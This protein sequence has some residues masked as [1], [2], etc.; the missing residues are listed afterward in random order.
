MRLFRLRAIVTLAAALAAPAHAAQL[1][2]AR[3]IT[4]VVPD[5]PGGMS[6]L[7]A[8]VLAP[9]LARV[10]NQ[11]VSVENDPAQD[12]L[13]AAWRVSRSPWD[14]YTLLLAP[15]ATL[16]DPKKH[17]FASVAVVSTAPL[18]LVA[19]AKSR[20]RGV[21][22]L[23]KLA[24][25]K[26]GSLSYGAV[27][28]RRATG[29]A[30]EYFKSVAGVDLRRVQF[31]TAAEAL[32]AL[33][34]GKVDVAFVPL[35]E[36]LAPVAAGSLLALAVTGAARA[37]ALPEVPTVSESGYTG[38]EAVDWQG[39]M[40]PIATPTPFVATHNADVNKVLALPAVRDAL[41]AL[42]VEP[43]GGTSGRLFDL[44]R[45]DREQWPKLG[46]PATGKP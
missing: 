34:A 30:G 11:P 38:F 35:A 25:A 45:M 19:K 6:D 8:R 22:E 23:V 2:P 13:S 39:L 9:E 10:W 26:P 12:G 46:V 36:A 1:F 40:L 15:T 44:I 16:D 5:A 29:L 41:L 43:G 28:S 27:G 24:K 7:L 31:G 33:A 37:H 32:A 21:K 4:I 3:P 42:G 14:A 17:Y 18:A 20:H